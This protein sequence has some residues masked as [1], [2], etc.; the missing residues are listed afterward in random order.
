VTFGQPSK[1]SFIGVSAFAG[2]KS[3]KRLHIVASVSSIGEDFVLRSGVREITVDSGKPHLRI[4]EDF[5]M[6]GDSVVLY[7]G[8]DREV[9]VPSDVLV[10]KN[11]S[12]DGRDALEAVS[13]EGGSQL[14]SI[15]E[16]AFGSGGSLLSIRL[17]ASLEVIEEGAFCFCWSLVE[18]TF[19]APSKLRVIARH[20]FRDCDALT[21]ITLPGSLRA[22]HEQS[23]V[24]CR[25]LKSVTFERGSER[26]KIH[27]D[28]F[29]RCPNLDEICP[30]EYARSL[31]LE[32]QFV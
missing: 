2:C 4:V 11:R 7:F 20:A 18:L 32:R 25:S 29:A 16:F 23:F 14:Q 1:I 15:G 5:V 30:R 21:S 22:I 6:G 27:R 17:P 13:F 24:W 31:R 19:E 3:L 12:F 10:L 8:F 9:V 26:A 28:A